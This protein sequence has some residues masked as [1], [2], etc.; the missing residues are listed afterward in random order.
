MVSEDGSAMF[1]VVHLDPGR[2]E[3]CTFKHLVNTFNYAGG[4]PTTYKG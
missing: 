2:A 1:S 3:E 4:L